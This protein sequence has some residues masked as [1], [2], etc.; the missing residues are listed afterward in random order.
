MQNGPQRSRSSRA[1]F[2]GRRVIGIFAVILRR[3]KAFHRGGGPWRW[4]GPKRGAE[5]RGSRS[6]RRRTRGRVSSSSRTAAASVGGGASDSLARAASGA[7]CMKSAGP[8]APAPREGEEAAAATLRPRPT[9]RRRRRRRRPIGAAAGDPRWR[10]ARIDDGRTTLLFDVASD[11]ASRRRRAS[12]RAPARRCA[13]AS[14]RGGARRAE[15]ARAEAARGRA[16]R[17]SAA[18]PVL[19]ELSSNARAR[20]SYPTPGRAASKA[21]QTPHR[22]FSLVAR[23]ARAASPRSTLEGPRSAARRRLPVSPRSARRAR[24]GSHRGV[25]AALRRS[26]SARR[27]SATRH[28]VPIEDR[29]HEAKS[30]EDHRAR[31]RRRRDS[32]E[33]LAANRALRTRG[34]AATRAASPLGEVARAMEKMRARRSVCP[35]VAGTSRSFGAR[36]AASTTRAPGSPPRLHRT[37]AAWPKRSSWPPRRLL[38]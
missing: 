32:A 33:L 5:D 7:R 34:G 35:S 10:R 21:V 37:A 29:F 19:S 36:L 3:H 38:V 30:R 4:D 13:R 2:R 11:R 18:T 20:E 6:E 17:R 25:P 28:F 31:R 24:H 26:S 14:S 16:P 23:P 27:A 12:A 8:R 22:V 1:L 9:R 15:R